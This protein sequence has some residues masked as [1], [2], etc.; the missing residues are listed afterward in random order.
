MVS[1]LNDVIPPI[2]CEAAVPSGALLGR[3]QGEANT[4]PSANLKALRA[5]IGELTFE[6]DFYEGPITK[7]GLLNARR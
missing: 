5:K 4:A 1:G 6:N 3:G 2:L 7:A